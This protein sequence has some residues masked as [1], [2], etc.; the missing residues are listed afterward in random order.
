MFYLPCHSHLSPRSLGLGRAMHSVPRSARGLDSG[1]S[2]SLLRAGGCGQGWGRDSVRG[3]VSLKRSWEGEPTW[4]AV[5]PDGAR[6][7]ALIKG[8]VSR[9]S[10]AI[11]GGPG[12]QGHL[13]RLSVGKGSRPSRR[14]GPVAHR[15]RGGWGRGRMG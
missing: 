13:L 2:H 15:R 7:P 9:G 1:S 6:S 12:L 5:G 8:R 10:A 4:A 11:V 3:R 14:W